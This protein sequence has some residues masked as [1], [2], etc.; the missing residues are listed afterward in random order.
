MFLLFHLM[1]KTIP[2]FNIKEF[3]LILKEEDKLTTE[4]KNITLNWNIPL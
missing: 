1:I 3:D 2:S 4:I